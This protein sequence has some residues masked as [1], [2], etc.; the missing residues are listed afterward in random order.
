MSSLQLI[1]A[2]ADQLKKTQAL[3]MNINAAKGLQEVLKSNVG[4]KGT[5]KMLVGGAGQIKITKDGNVLLHEMQ[6]QHPTA[7]MIARA[8]TAQDDMVGDGTSS[9]VLF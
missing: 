1:N 3:I 4:P 9:N 7:S 5:Y 2:K 6:I 8:A